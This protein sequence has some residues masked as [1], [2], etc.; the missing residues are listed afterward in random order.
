MSAR[1][2]IGLPVYNGER[3]LPAAVDSILSQTYT[4]FELVISDN[5]STDSTQELCE[6]YAAQDERVKYHRSEQNRGGTWNF[7]RV[8]EL[9]QGEF[10][11]WAAHDDA[12]APTYLERCVAAL[13]ANPDAVLAHTRVEII[14]GDDVSAGVYDAP[15]MRLDDDRVHVRFHDST[16]YHG[17]CHLIFGV[18]RR[19]ALDRI[20]AYGAYGHADGVLLARLIMLGKFV[21]LDEPL[22]LMREH[23]DQAS[24][25]YGVKGGLDYLAWRAWFDPKYADALGLPVLADRRRVRPKPGRGARCAA[26]RT[27]SMH[28]RRLGSRLDHQG[29]HEAG[30]HPSSSHTRGP[31][32]G[33]PHVGNPGTRAVVR[34]QSVVAVAVTHG[35]HPP[36]ASTLAWT[37]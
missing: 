37:S 7:N 4:D 36:S 15:P 5:G 9:S 1:V 35:C 18:M 21:Q 24:T 22:Q 2:S 10:F 27:C 11:R 30:P 17:R 13:D 16:T 25:T 12:I 32:P 3:Y 23:A 20:P 29:A 6:R 26:R 19:S 8:V 28:R 31:S 33:S 14:D 34:V